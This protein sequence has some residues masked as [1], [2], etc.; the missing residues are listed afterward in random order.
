MR[1]SQPN[2]TQQVPGKCTCRSKNNG[3]FDD[4]TKLTKRQQSI[5]EFCADCGRLSPHFS[6]R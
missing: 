5:E 6:V 3:N 1:L 4:K 2:G